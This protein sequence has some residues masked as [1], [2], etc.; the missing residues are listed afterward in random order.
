MEA[1]TTGQCLYLFHQEAQTKINV[2]K[3][4]MLLV[5]VPLEIILQ[6]CCVQWSPGHHLA[7]RI[8][9]IWLWSAKSRKT[10]RLTLHLLFTPRGL[11]VNTHLLRILT[12]Q[13]SLGSAAISLSAIS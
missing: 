5:Q 1:F 6:D 4:E 2:I 11:E 10:I 13:L 12:G 7:L 8:P 9:D 3:C